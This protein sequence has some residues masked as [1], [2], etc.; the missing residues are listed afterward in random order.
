MIKEASVGFFNIISNKPTQE[1]N[2]VGF[3][4]LEGIEQP[5]FLRSMDKNCTAASEQLVVYHN[6]GVELLT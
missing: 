3:H 4:T 6:G 5:K 1:K 2:N